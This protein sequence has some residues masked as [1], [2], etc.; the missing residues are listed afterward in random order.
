MSAGTGA[1]SIY[2]TP[3][4]DVERAREADGIDAMKAPRMF[5]VSKYISR[6]ARREEFTDDAPS[7]KVVWVG[8]AQ[9]GAESISQAYKAHL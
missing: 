7:R 8:E 1:A 6:T 5:D 2:P 9:G 3:R 4:P